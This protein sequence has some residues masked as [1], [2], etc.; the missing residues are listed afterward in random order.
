MDDLTAIVE[1]HAVR[2][3]T[4][5]PISES[6]LKVL[7]NVIGESNKESGLRM[8]LAVNE[9]RAFT[10]GLARYGKFNN[11][12]NYLALVGPKGPD[13]EEKCG[14]YGER[15]VLEAQ[16]LGLNSCWVGLTYDKANT[17]YALAD[18]EKLVIVVALGHGTTQGVSRKSKSIAQVSRV[19]PGVTAPEW[20]EQG[21]AAALLAPSSMNQQLY[22]FEYTGK[23]TASGRPVIAARTLPAPYANVDL[24]IAKLHFE[25]AVGAPLFVWD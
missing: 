2:S 8:Q 3:F 23:T 12:R 22:K 21:V 15:V 18:R 20:F 9:P 24:G 6:D 25:I 1:R 14:Y 11:V 4:D 19:A 5:E 17:R 16:K 10:G 7:H 13:L